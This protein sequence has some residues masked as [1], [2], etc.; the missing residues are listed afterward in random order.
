MVLEDTCDICVHKVFQAGAH[1]GHAVLLSYPDELW[2]FSS[3]R[4]VLD[5]V[6]R[7]D[8]S[9]L[10]C[11]ASCPRSAQRGFWRGFLGKPI[12]RSMRAHPCFIVCA[13]VLEKD[14]GAFGR[15]CALKCKE[16]ERMLRHRAVSLMMTPDQHVWEHCFLDSCFDSS[17]SHR[18]LHQAVQ[19]EG[20]SYRNTKVLRSECL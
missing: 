18:G 5:V 3:I 12:T 20:H 19:W 16:Y 4:C 10:A 17:R 6:R 7:P 11:W 1:S 13:I 14:R 15:S 8:R 2:S 9:A